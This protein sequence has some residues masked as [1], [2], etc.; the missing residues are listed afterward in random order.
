[1]S[2]LRLNWCKDIGFND[3][4]AILHPA[5]DP[6]IWFSVIIPLLYGRWLLEYD[7]WSS[8][9]GNTLNRDILVWPLIFVFSI[10]FK[11]WVWLSSLHWSC[12]TFQFSGKEIFAPSGFSVFFFSYR[13]GKLWF[14]LRIYQQK[15]C[16]LSTALR[17]KGA[18]TASLGVLFGCP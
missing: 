17:K 13:M 1:M 2:H 8:N 4:F 10:H 6:L 9:P 16:I 18:E 5:L 15:H 14:T 12:I 3:F 11:W 7:L